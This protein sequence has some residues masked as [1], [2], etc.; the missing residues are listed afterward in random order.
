MRRMADTLLCVWSPR[1][2][3]TCRTA[4]QPPGEMPRTASFSTITGPGHRH[5][6]TVEGR[7]ARWYAPFGRGPY[8]AFGPIL[9]EPVLGNWDRLFFVS[10]RR[11]QA[12]T[13]ASADAALSRAVSFGRGPSPRTPGPLL[14]PT[15]PALPYMPLPAAGLAPR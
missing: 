11:D 15:V 13:P 3:P 5:R 9:S 6:A 10:R 8:V 4:G 7:P 2:P 12:V 1:S 14:G